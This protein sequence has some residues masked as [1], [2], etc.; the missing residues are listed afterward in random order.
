[1]C[2]HLQHPAKLWQ[3]DLVPNFGKN[4]NVSF[5]FIAQTTINIE[6]F[7]TIL[8]V[9]APTTCF[10]FRQ[11]PMP[12]IKPNLCTF[13]KQGLANKPIFT[14]NPLNFLLAPHAAE[15]EGCRYV[16]PPDEPPVS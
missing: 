4:E 13:F 11:P 2:D 6:Q 7:I 14:L 1:M 16:Q 12:A 8:A 15:A 9:P 10:I 5:A 3:R